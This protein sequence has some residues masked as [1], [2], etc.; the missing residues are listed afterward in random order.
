MKKIVSFLTNG[1]INLFVGFLL[2]IFA[3][4]FIYPYQDSLHSPSVAFGV[5]LFVA[6][7][8]MGYG[9]STLFRRIRRSKDDRSSHA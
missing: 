2:L 6:T 5:L 1:W 3:V 8:I 7:D 9:F 4:Y